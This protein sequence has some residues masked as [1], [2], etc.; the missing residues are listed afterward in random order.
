MLKEPSARLL[1]K[2]LES[3]LS[4]FGSE[5]SVLGSRGAPPVVVNNC[6]PACNRLLPTDAIEWN[7]SCRPLCC[8]HRVA[9]R[10]A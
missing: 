3:T 10:S 6:V 9:A 2:L 7:R 5:T 1:A 8:R 4:M